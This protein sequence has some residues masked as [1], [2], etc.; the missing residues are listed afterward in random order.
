V[1]VASLL[2]SVSSSEPSDC[3]PVSA[4]AVALVN[5][6]FQGNAIVKKAV[7]S[8]TDPISWHRIVLGAR[9]FKKRKVVVHKWHRMMLRLT[10]LQLGSVTL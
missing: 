8:R 4:R 7:P 10:K 9:H 1:A 3:C 6:R 5:M 2:E